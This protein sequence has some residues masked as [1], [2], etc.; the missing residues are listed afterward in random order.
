[1]KHVLYLLSM[2]IILLGCMKSQI[3]DS[4]AIQSQAKKDFVVTILANDFEDKE[5]AECLQNGLKKEFPKVKFIPGNKF[6]NAL[7]PW[8]EPSTA[9]DEITEFSAIFTETEVQKRIKAL[10]VEFLIYVHGFTYQSDFSGYVG[11]YG[12]AAGYASAKRETYIKTSV[13]DLG[14]IAIVGHTNIHFEGTVHLPIL[15]I[16]VL[17][18]AFTESS[19]CSETAKRISNCLT[20]ERSHKDKFDDR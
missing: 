9:P 4:L 14:K 1:M 8:F 5:F 12:A 20:G 13:W 2:I 18:P 6:R 7:F 3:A 10:G 16:P 11:G 15:G 19:A 17:I